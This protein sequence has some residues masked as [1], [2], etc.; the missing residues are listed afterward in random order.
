MAMWLFLASLTMLFVAGMMGYVVIRLRMEKHTPLGT[1]S[2]P[3]MLWVSTAL[4]MAASYTIHMALTAVRFEN[5]SAFKRLMKATTVLACLFVLV[6]VPALAQVLRSHD[7]A[8]QQGVGLYGLVF[9]LILLHAAHVLG[10][11]LSL[12]IVTANASKGLYDHESHAPI[13][14]AAMYWHFLDAVWLI[15]FSLMLAMG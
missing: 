1:L 12:F 4:V 13:R 11:I 3:K 9:F 15:M 8:Q 14:Y 2:I 10:G 5:Q 6:Q 7:I